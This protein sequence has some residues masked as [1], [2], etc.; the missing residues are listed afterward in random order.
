MTLHG[1]TLRAKPCTIDGHRFPSQMEAREYG[2]LKMLQRSGHIT[3]L[4]LQVN[5]PLLDDFIYQGKKV[6][7]FGWKA[8]FVVTYKSGKTVV[9]EVKGVETREWQRVKK[10]FMSR[11][12]DIE[13]QVVRR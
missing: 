12:P 8:D 5:F 10:M 4:K 7:G 3:D 11:Y 6:K 1:N 13:L 9:R 2:R